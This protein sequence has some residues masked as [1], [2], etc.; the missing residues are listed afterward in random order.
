MILIGIFAHMV[1]Y[2][3][4]YVRTGSAP[5][6]KPVNPLRSLSTEFELLL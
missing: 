3:S 5:R 4:V 6:T 2:E 1:T